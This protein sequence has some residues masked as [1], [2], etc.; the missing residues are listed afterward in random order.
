MLDKNLAC[1]LFSWTYFCHLELGGGEE[2][3]SL[4]YKISLKTVFFF[5]FFESSF[6][7]P[8]DLFF[9]FRG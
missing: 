4:L 2:A 6:H 5:F 7:A 3:L 8:L 9:P 1:D